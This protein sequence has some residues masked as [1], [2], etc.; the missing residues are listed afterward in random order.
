VLRYNLSNLITFIRNQ[1][2]IDRTA[3]KVNQ[4]GIMLTL[5]ISFLVSALWPPATLLVPLLAAVLLLGPV[6]PRAAVFKQL[7]SHVLRPAGILTAR[8]VSESS[9]P[10]NFAQLLGGLVLALASLAFLASA[11]LVGWVLAWI[12]LLLAFANLAF[13]F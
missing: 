5:L 9:R 2:M 1:G 11:P 3:G 10:H 4:A 7:Y 13:G 6:E 8:P 12:V